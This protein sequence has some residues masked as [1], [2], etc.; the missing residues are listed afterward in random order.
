MNAAQATLAVLWLG[1]TLYA[2]F[3]GADF[4]AG[5]WDLFAGGARRGRPQR[6]LIEHVIG[7][8][9]EANHVWLIFVLVLLWTGFSPVFAAIMSTLYI[10]LTLAALGVIG[11]GAAFA[12][13]KVVDELWQ[14]RLFG[15]VFAASSILTPFFMGTVAGAI[16]SGRV[17][18]GLAAGNL[19]TSW[20]NPTGVLGGIL[21]VGTC[22]YL[23]AMYLCHD[24]VRLGR[25]DLA[26]AFRRRALA[27]AVVVG[28]V[29][30]GGIVVVRADAPA[31]FHGLTH[32]GLPLVIVST[33]SGLVSLALLV[34]RR[35]VPVRS[36]SALAVAAVLWGWALAQYPR[37]LPPDLD[38]A[39]AA[40]RPPVLTATLITVGIGALL[41]LPSLG[42]LYIV[43]QHNQIP[44]RNRPAASRH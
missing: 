13:R 43:F 36:M 1:L 20:L 42:W 21:A 10:P 25:P 4:G 35:Y 39:V 6:D 37:V 29:V 9:W 44:P 12:F 41:L 2:L 14:Q 8:V 19:V 3:A 28:V 11:R 17:P 38:Y 32:R 23:A 18:P 31:L 16:A 7:P 22:A 5:F 34:A 27:V 40:A 24:A 26:D 15:A 30:L 33:L